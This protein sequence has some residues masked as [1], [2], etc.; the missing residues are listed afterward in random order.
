MMTVLM[1]PH[2]S[3]LPLLEESSNADNR[4]TL[5]KTKMPEPKSN[6]QQIKQKD[7]RD[8]LKPVEINDTDEV[9][10]LASDKADF[11]QVLQNHVKIPKPGR[12]NFSEP[13]D[14]EK[15]IMK[16]N[17]KTRI[18]IY[19]QD[20]DRA[21]FQS[22]KTNFREV[23][24]PSPQL[25][26]NRK[27]TSE[28]FQPE[29]N[30]EASECRKKLNPVRRKSILE[31]PRID[32]ASKPLIQA[33]MGLKPKATSHTKSEQSSMPDNSNATRHLKSKI[34]QIAPRNKNTCR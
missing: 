28:S 2:K 13:P 18:P 20:H 17:L 10:C 26:D 19:S 34:P 14:G 11:R 21:I 33:R 30:I 29:E 3:N 23:L 31:Q 8:V 24:N 4:S 1:F 12:K 32:S 9:D 27:K 15:Q 22:S 5:R 16:D 6:I 7:M 25:E